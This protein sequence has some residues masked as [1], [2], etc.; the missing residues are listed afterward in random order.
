MTSIEE[1]RAGDIATH[2]PKGLRKRSLDQS[3]A[4]GDAIARGNTAA[5]RAVQADRVDLVEVGDCTVLFCNVADSRDWRDVTIHAVDTFE[6]HDLRAGRIHRTHQL[7]E[8]R[9][10]VVAK[11]KAL[12]PGAADTFDH[13]IMIERVGKDGTVRQKAPE[14]C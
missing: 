13:R 14:R 2:H 9:D 4:M 7:V 8:M 1:S 11:D 5:T 10:I 12:R 3:H 6:C